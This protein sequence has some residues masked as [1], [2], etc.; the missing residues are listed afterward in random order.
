MIYIF[1][2]KFVFLIGK[3]QSKFVTYMA[4]CP[5]PQAT[6]ARITARLLTVPQT[7]QN[8]TRVMSCRYYVNHGDSIRIEKESSALSAARNYPVL[9]L[10]HGNADDLGTCEHYCKWLG[11]Q[12]EMHVVTYDYQG[13]GH[14]SPL[15][16]D[17]ESMRDF[18]GALY[19]DVRRNL[20]GSAV[21]L[22]GKSVGSVPTMWL[23][24]QDI[25]YSGVIIV[26]GMASGART[27]FSK[28][29]NM[30]VCISNPL[31]SIFG[32]NMVWEQNL[33]GPLLIIHG[34]DDNVIPV[35]NADILGDRVPLDCKC[36]KILLSADHNDI[37]TRH[38]HVFLSGMAHFITENAPVLDS[39]EQPFTDKQTLNPRQLFC[40]EHAM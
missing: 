20:P 24:A 1:K 22:M 7:T 4:F 25:G 5:P 8:P 36:T 10:S 32:N 15:P 35:I 27:V 38:A 21:F 28:L 13:Y 39:F 6:Y 33:H 19:E 16:C 17:E 34:K 11:F 12:L 3:S 9:L 23:A 18:V 30:P 29:G 14:S 37:E 40:E 2:P 31:D 26:S